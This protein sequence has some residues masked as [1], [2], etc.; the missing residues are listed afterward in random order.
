MVGMKLW[1]AGATLCSQAG[2]NNEAI[3]RRASVAVCVAKR[4][5]WRASARKIGEDDILVRVTRKSLIWAIR[6]SSGLEPGIR[7]AVGKKA[8]LSEMRSALVEQQYTR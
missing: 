7:S 4:K 1:G 5:G 8:T 6:S 2:S 3:S